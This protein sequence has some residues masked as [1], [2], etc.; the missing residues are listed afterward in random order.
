MEEGIEEDVEEEIE[1]DAGEA[2]SSGI[3][4]KNENFRRLILEGEEAEKVEGI[5]GETLE[6][7]KKI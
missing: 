6:N 3:T 2:E 7:M 4:S 5:V 1:G